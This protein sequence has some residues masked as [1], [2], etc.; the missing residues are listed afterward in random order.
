MRHKLV[1]LLVPAS[2][3]SRLVSGCA[4]AATPIATAAPGP[5]PAPA[6]VVTASVAELRLTVPRT[7]PPALDGT[8]SSGEWSTA[9]RRIASYRTTASSC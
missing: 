1:V 6:P 9:T 2:L 7:A 8:L 5:T 4:T 3:A